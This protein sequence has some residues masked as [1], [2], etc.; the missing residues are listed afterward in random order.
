MNLADS[1]LS[2]PNV[3]FA[4][5]SREDGDDRRQ[6]DTNHK[7]DGLRCCRNGANLRRPQMLKTAGHG[8]CCG[9][10]SSL[11]VAMET[12]AALERLELSEMDANTRDSE[13]PAKLSDD[14]PTEGVERIR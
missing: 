4:A 10:C 11:H 13:A 3:S 2:F 5:A 7:K 1:L 14:D 6:A 8:Q 9:Q 12:I